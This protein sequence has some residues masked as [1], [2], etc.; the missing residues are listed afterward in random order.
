[1]RKT[2]IAMTCITLKNT[3]TKQVNFAQP[4]TILRDSRF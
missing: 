3:N 4:N 2:H 1:M